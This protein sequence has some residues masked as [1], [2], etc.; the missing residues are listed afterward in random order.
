M[1]EQRRSVRAPECVAS[2]PLRDGV[3]SWV[4]PELIALTLRVWSP[5]Y[6]EPLTAEDA[7]AI[8][9]DTGR[10]LAVLKER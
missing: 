7:V 4:T 10:L 3:P 2:R 6:P 1:S 5:R 8:L 9:V